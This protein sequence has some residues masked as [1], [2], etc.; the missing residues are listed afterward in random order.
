VAAVACFVELK[1]MHEIKAHHIVGPDQTVPMSIFWLLPQYVLL[2]IGDVFIAVGMLEFFYDQSPE[3][4]QSLGT[5]FFTSGIGVGNFLNSF[6]VTVVDKLTRRGGGK[7]WIGNNL[8]DSHLDYYY[9]FIIA[10]SAVN[11]GFFF[12]VSS[13]YS[14][15]KEKLEVTEEGK[16]LSSGSVVVVV[17]GVEMKGIYSPSLGLQV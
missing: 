3:D 4:M 7:S 5:T 10:I 2:G 12:W 17:Q 6:L 13:R 16:V 9:G 15:K 1:R 14:Y 8:N 11:L